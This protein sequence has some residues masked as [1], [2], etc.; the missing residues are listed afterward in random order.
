VR[1]LW[2]SSDRQN[3]KDTDPSKIATPGRSGIM[4]DLTI[5]KAIF[6]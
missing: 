6:F 1:L 5:F 2:R 4:R 3:K